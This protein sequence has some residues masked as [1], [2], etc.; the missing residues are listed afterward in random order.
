MKN[1]VDK[2][3]KTLTNDGGRIHNIE[4]HLEKVQKILGKCSENE[5]ESDGDD[6][7]RIQTIQESLTSVSRTLHELSGEGDEKGI[8]STIQAEVTNVKN[9]LRS[10][11]GEDGNEGRIKNLENSLA[12][13][14]GSVQELSGQDN[15]SG[16]IKNLEDAVFALAGKDNQSGRIRNLESD[17]AALKNEVDHIGTA[18]HSS[19]VPGQGHAFFELSKKHVRTTLA[20]ENNDNDNEETLKNHSCCFFIL[21]YLSLMLRIVSRGSSALLLVVAAVTIASNYD[22]SRYYLINLVIFGVI[23]NSVDT[24]VNTIVGGSF[25]R[26]LF[27]LKYMI[28]C[29]CEGVQMWAAVN[30]YN[31]FIAK[32]GDVHFFIAIVGICDS[33]FGIARILLDSC[34]LWM[35]QYTKNDEFR[36]YYAI[37]SIKH[38]V[39]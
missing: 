6:R 7:A 35:G 2:L 38:V 25:F 12:L 21:V 14:Q 28:W 39:D 18:T 37:T 9:A 11:S 16:R 3:C 22:D 5:E 19:K 33:T 27:F 20:K 13:I 31:Y 24:S 1:N 15:Q 17:L 30:M 32:Q 10:L 26:D 36:H 34:V 23:S 8:I 29:A 4:T